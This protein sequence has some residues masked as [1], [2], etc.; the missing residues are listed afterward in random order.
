MRNAIPNR[1]KTPRGRTQRGGAAPAL[2]ATPRALERAVDRAL[3]GQRAVYA[4]E[5]ERLVQ[6][7]LALIRERSDLEPPV[8]AIVRRARLSNQAF[9]RHFRGKHELLVAVLDHGIALLEGYLRERM[10]AAPSASERVRAWLRGMLEQ[11]LN[12]RGAEA[13]RP[14]ALARSQLAR[15][16]PEEVAA[17]EQRLSALVR[18]A[19]A[20][21]KRA[22]ELP[23][24]DPDS[25]SEALYHLAMGWLE[26]RLLEDDPTERAQAERLEAFA[27]AGLHASVSKTSA[28]KRREIRATADR[29]S[30]SRKRPHAGGAG[31]GRAQRGRSPS[32]ES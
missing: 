6:A 24:A 5:A 12:S 31:A 23:S 19:I 18:E 27:M 32:G 26:T 7:A 16:Y 25:D 17:S 4:A 2:G 9:Y 3:E 30:R 13:T 1:R 29:S 11:A 10:A 8:A 15:H 28:T 21:A 22:G 20:D 14:F